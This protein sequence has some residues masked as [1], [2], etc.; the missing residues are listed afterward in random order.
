MNTFDIYFKTV[1]PLRLQSLFLFFEWDLKMLV[2]FPGWASC[3]T[4]PTWPGV[5]TAC[6]ASRSSWRP[7]W[8]S[9][10]AASST[11][12]RST[13]TRCTTAFVSFSREL[14]I[15]C[16]SSSPIEPPGALFVLMCHLCACVSVCVCEAS[17][18]ML[19]AWQENEERAAAFAQVN[20]FSHI[21]NLWPAAST[22]TLV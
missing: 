6:L 7:S 11:T 22:Y 21:N 18:K 19:K 2:S 8:T 16:L 4:T 12:W 9:S 17:E 1:S 13:A 20:F 14:F 15:N 10:R 3:A 5:R